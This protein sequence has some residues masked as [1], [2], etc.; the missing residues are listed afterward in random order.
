[1][2]WPPRVCTR[3]WAS[4]AIAILGPVNNFPL[5]RW[6]RDGSG[7]V[8]SGAMTNNR[9][10]ARLGYLEQSLLGLAQSYTELK[11]QR[12]CEVYIALYYSDF[13]DISEALF[14]SYI[15]KNM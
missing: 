3:T 12:L 11:A 1:M 10:N 6:L 7:A 15:D 14:A 5:P 2:S 4:F 8:D 9:I 13:N